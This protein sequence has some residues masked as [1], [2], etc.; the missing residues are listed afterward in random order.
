MRFIN[1][2]PL[3]NGVWIRVKLIGRVEQK[4]HIFSNHLYLGSLDG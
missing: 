4:K 1:G 3:K 2:N